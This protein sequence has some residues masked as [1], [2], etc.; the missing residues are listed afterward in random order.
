MY[1]RYKFKY[2][3]LAC[4]MP[5]NYRPNILGVGLIDHVNYYKIVLFRVHL[6]KSKKRKNASP[7]NI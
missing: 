5:D 7:W 3:N 4:N 6:K 1:E 2:A